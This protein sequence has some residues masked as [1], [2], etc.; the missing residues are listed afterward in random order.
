MTLP[1]MKDDPVVSQWYQDL[2]GDA[3]ISRN[4]WFLIGTVSL[5]LT[6]ILG[7]ALIS[8]VPLKTVEPYVI[9]VDNKSGLTTVLKPLRENHENTLTE[10]EAVTK[11]FIVKY[12]IARETY[13]PQDLNR[14]YEVV[15]LM[16]GPDEAERFNK[17][18]TDGNKDSPIE[19]FKTTTTRTIRI[20]SVSFLDKQKKTAQVRLAAME[21]SRI[22]TRESYWVAILTFRY[23]NAPMDEQD[24]LNNPLGF[25]VM[26]YRLDQEMI[27]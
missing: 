11:S 4:R 17:W 3:V 25:Q 19:R 26:S 22:E 2:Y 5:A 1:I 15:R 13:D 27:R 18:I 21:N 8:L 16:S 24:R 10:E 7:I 23:V 6:C 9:Q 12:V 14:N 20:T